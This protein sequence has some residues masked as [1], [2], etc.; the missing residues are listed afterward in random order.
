MDD[1]MPP[2][3]RQLTAETFG[4]YERVD[5][6]WLLSICDPEL[7]IHQP[8]EFPDAHSYYGPEA[9]I[10]SLLDWPRQWQQF[11]MEPVRIYAPDDEHIMLIAIHH[12]RARLVDL[13][14]EAEIMFLLG[15]QDGRLRT[16]E[17]F[18]SEEEALRRAAER[19]AHRDDDRAAEGD[20]GEGAQEAGP[21]EARADHG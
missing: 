20:G 6:D 16:F 17:M 12:G 13:E 7:E 3:L 8:R 14:V 5:L 2:P 15:V 18:L 4:A 11:H 1:D 10:D 9:L 19:R 21:E